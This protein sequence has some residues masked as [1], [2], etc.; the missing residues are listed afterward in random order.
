MV[1][2]NLKLNLKTPKKIQRIESRTNSTDQKFLKEVLAIIS[3]YK[4]KDAT[5]GQRM[6]LTSVKKRNCF[7]NV[8]FYIKKATRS[9]IKVIFKANFTFWFGVLNS[10]RLNQ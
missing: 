3:N 2:Q 6:N 5:R 1:T 9:K 10:P 8:Q 4:Y 7:I